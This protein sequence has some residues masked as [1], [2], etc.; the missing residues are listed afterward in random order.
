MKLLPLDTPELLDLAARW[1]GD[2]QTYQWL[3]FGNGR[4]IVTPAL[5]KVMTQRDTHYLRVYTSDEDDTP[6]GVVGL[7]NVDRNFKVGTLWVVAGEKSSRNRGYATRA[8]SKILTLAFEELGLHAVN[9][10]IVEHNPSVRVAEHLKLRFIGRQ[11]QCHYID[12]RAHD[13]LL[14]DILA[15]EHRET[16]DDRKPGIAGTSR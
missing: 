5:L 4:Q 13:R 2:K 1:L 15:S 16:E 8:C 9:T 11:R 7:N 3:D 6:I 14:F 10:W 12:G